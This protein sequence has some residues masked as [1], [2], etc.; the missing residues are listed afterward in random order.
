[1]KGI[2]RGERIFYL[3]TVHTH[4]PPHWST[5]TKTDKN[6]KL[7]GTKLQFPG[8]VREIESENGA[9]IKKKTKFS[10][11]IRKYEK[12][13]AVAKSYMTNSLLIYD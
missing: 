1:V 12:G 6:A 10:S 4:F 3:H 7:V 13:A 2:E 9:L 5:S 11:Y 8:I